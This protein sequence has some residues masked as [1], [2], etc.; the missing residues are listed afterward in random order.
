MTSLLQVLG[1]CLSASCGG[2]SQPTRNVTRSHT[3]DYDTYQ[4][5]YKYET[6]EINSYEDFVLGN[7]YHIEINDTT[8]DSVFNYD[9]GF[10]FNFFNV[11]RLDISNYYLNSF[12]FDI[13]TFDLY[14]VEYYLTLEKTTQS[15]E[16]TF[17]TLKC[18][19]G[20]VFLY[21]Q[22]T[23]D[24][25]D[26]DFT[27]IGD[28]VLNSM[29]SNE[30]LQAYDEYISKCENIPIVSV[31]SISHDTTILGYIYDFVYTKIF[32]MPNIDNYSWTIGG[33]TTT[34][35]TWLSVSFCI[36]VGSLLLFMLIWFVRYLFR[37]FSGLLH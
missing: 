36:V 6:N 8:A 7:A 34:M 23:I 12:E 3:V 10:S 28:F 5:T 30:F 37:L 20:D 16:F 18:E 21:D 11:E 2:L 14:D 32:N 9:V 35:R 1:L 26:N 29:T 4:V 33:Q 13:D 22:D 15:Y 31:E 17:Y 24:L 25:S 27:L 19:N